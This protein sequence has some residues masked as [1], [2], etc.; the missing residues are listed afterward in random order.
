VRQARPGI[1]GGWLGL[2][3]ATARPAMAADTNAPV[4]T[5][6]LADTNAV[7]Q[8]APS[9]GFSWDA[10]TSLNPE[11]YG[12]LAGALVGLIVIV[13]L[14]VK[15][16]GRKKPAPETVSGGAGGQPFKA[17]PQCNI[18]S[19]RPGQRKLWRFA[20]A[21]R[22]KVK[23]DHEYVELPEEN[24][25]AKV[26]GRG[27]GDLFNPRLN[28]AWLP[29]DRVFLRVAEFP[30]GD[31]EELRAMVELQL[32]KL[33]PLPVTQ[34]VW[35]IE[36]L[37]PA[38]GSEGMAP[39]V[40]II[41]SRHEVEKRLGQLEQTGFLADRLELP[42]LHQLLAAHKPDDGVWFIPRANAEAPSVLI[43]WWYGGT[44][45]NLTVAN[46]SEPSKWEKELGSPLA[47]VAWSGELE[48]W[49]TGQAHFHLLADSDQ[50]DQWKPVLEKVTGEPVTVD[51]PLSEPALAELNARKA[52]AGQ[53][54]ANLM[55]RDLLESYRQRFIDAIWMRGLGTVF[56]VYVFGVLL[57]FL[58]IEGLKLQLDNLR[59]EMRQ[60]SG[61]YTNALMAKARVEV[62]QEQIA[63][64]FAALESLKAV[65]ANLPEGMVLTSFDFS[66]GRKITLRGTVPTEDIANVS[67]FHKDLARLKVNGQLLFIN[68]SPPAMGGRGGEMSWSFSAELNSAEI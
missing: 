48:G 50:V 66:K 12:Y 53:S 22:G 8:D 44:L 52:A 42:E 62:L 26:V 55:P 37:P 7:A 28:I 4:A 17:P 67:K 65:S 33:S 39:V 5:N 47:Q 10:L 60:W 57:Y 3:A 68:V 63:L 46:L 24:M 29:S 11:Q 25:P 19:V 16:L 21:G 40:I 56:M 31:A 38:A 61:P 2:V 15:L 27:W 14:L 43:A 49:Y 45:R 20:V 23:L 35:A 6:S 32:E 9:G 34:I 41:A 59:V 13:L 36:P 30:A 64:K 54:G 18:V 58:A 1:H 51:E